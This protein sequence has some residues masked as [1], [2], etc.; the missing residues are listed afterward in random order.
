MHTQTVA[1]ALAVPLTAVLLAAPAAHARGET[2]EPTPQAPVTVPPTG[3]TPVLDPGSD[4]GDA[5]RGH[6]EGENFVHAPRTAAPD[7]NS[8][9]QATWP[10]QP[11]STS[12]AAPAGSSPTPLPVTYQGP[13][14]VT[15]P[16]GFNV[17]DT[18][19]ASAFLV[20]DIDSGDILA[21]KDPHGRYRPASIIK[22]L[23]ALVAIDELPLDKVVTASA[24]TASQEGSLVGLVE[25]G[26]YTVDDLLHG[27]LLASGND[28][29]HA[30]AQELGGDAAAGQKVNAL[31]QRLGMRDTRA[32]SYSGL[33]APGMSSSVYDL[34]LAYQAAF[35]NPTFARIVDTDYY[36]FPGHA[37]LPGYQVWNDNHLY[38]EDPEGIGGKTGYTDDANH[39]FV[40]AVNHDGRR[41]VAVLLDTTSDK[42]RPWEQA[43]RLL[44]ESYRFTDAQGVDK[45]GASSPAGATQVTETATPGSS[46]EPSAVAGGADHA[47]TP[48]RSVA[49]VA[50]VVGAALLALAL[51]LASRARA[52][53][54]R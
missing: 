25:G 31:A 5:S 34:G 23:L 42:A 32:V 40:G 28:A 20:A 33:D 48:W 24:E 44:H 2:A 10:P 36:D 37:D 4:S 50:G 54:R 26:T 43:Q 1:R 17:D 29:A 18:V 30:L 7:T 8:C 41:L 22:V 45:L 3:G 39:T 11:V 35:R 21:M 12:E 51:S 14:G 47:P 49:I 38:L 6:Y 13:C 19:L 15:V 16:A 46:S 27:L 9:P 53:R 52:R